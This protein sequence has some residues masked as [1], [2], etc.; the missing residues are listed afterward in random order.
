[1]QKGK[2]P[3][4][5]SFASIIFIEQIFRIL[6]GNIDL[7]VLG[8]VSHDAVIAIGIVNQLVAICLVFISIGSIGTNVLLSRY[9]GAQ[10]EA[11]IKIVLIN[12]LIVTISIAVL[13]SISLSIF[14]PL[15][16]SSL[17]LEAIHQTY[18]SIYLSVI[19]FTFIIHACNMIMLVLLRNFQKRSI[20]LFT[21][22]TATMVNIVGNMLSLYFID[23]IDI[24]LKVVAMMTVCAHLFSFFVYLFY[25]KRMYQHFTLSIN[26]VELTSIL[27]IGA[28]S[29]LEHLS[30]VLFQF[31]ISW[32]VISWGVEQLTA[33]TYVQTW[34][35]FIFLFSITIG[36]ATQILIGQ[37]MG[38][39]KFQ[40]VQA[41]VKRS[42]WINICLVLLA[43]I[44]LL[45]CKK[46]LYEFFSI[47]HH[48]AY[49]MTALFI[50]TILLEPLR[51]VN[52]NM[53]SAL[54][55]CKDTTFPMFVSLLIL[56]GILFPVLFFF[57]SEWTIIILWVVMI[58]DEFIR[59][60][61]L[62][63]RWKK[64]RSKQMKQ[65]GQYAT[66]E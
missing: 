42:I 22:C 30:Y 20:I 62:T 6:Q 57:S 38:E 28:P 15:I 3:S 5:I 24:L 54:Y 29:A 43:S 50:L 4:L 51:S 1:M 17:K 58:I 16:F 12:G 64:V 10:D 65:M 7:L 18:G 25:C 27:Q 66:K 23:Q 56:W 59:M 26:K 33:K 40:S 13:L 47:N 36:Q 60:V 63:R 9:V 32:I 61:F 52:V 55:A 41:I 48:I 35:E 44:I 46:H 11:R 8:K 53:I 19:I 2:N 21:L 14:S 31:F 45:L 37:K 34:T 39:N 49:F